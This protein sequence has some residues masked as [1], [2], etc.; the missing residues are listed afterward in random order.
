M[1]RSQRV[2]VHLSVALLAVSASMLAAAFAR[3]FGLSSNAEASCGSCI[4]TFYGVSDATMATV[5]QNIWPQGNTCNCGVE[6][7]EAVVNFVDQMQGLPL[8]FT[9]TQD[10]FNINQ[11]MWGDAVISE[12][13]YATP[14]NP[15]AEKSNIAPDTGTDPR[16]IAYISTRY[17]PSGSM[18]YDY[19]YRWSFYHKTEPSFS[20][21][22]QE[23]TT[24]LAEGIER[25]HLPANTTINGGA[26]SVVVTGVWSGNDPN[27]HYPAQ[28]Q[29]LVFRD[30]EYVGTSSRFEVTFTTWSQ[31]GL[32]MPPNNYYYSL[33]SLYY[34]DLKNLNDHLNTSDPEPTMGPYV[35][36]AAQGEPYHW[37][38]GLTWIQFGTIYEPL[39]PHSASPSGGSAGP[40]NSASGSGLDVNPDWAYTA[41][42]PYT[43]GIQM[44]SP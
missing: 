28:I 24:S 11:D 42:T 31:T 17:S 21:Q 14:M 8:R 10:M 29:G 27:T 38:H 1:S 4:G 32:Y 43:F 19:I 40:P 13:G 30:P 16:S 3:G 41:P 44:Q 33:W 34:G 6:S 37:F 35:P 22:A 26:H 7:A 15:C 12:W 36:N 25:G 39:A 9:S 20:T 23:A 2:A 5:T 18:F